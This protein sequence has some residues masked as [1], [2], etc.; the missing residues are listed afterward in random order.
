MKKRNRPAASD[1]RA[2]RAKISAETTSSSNVSTYCLCKYIQICLR[3]KKDCYIDMH[4][5]LYRPHSLLCRSWHQRALRVRSTMMMT[6]TLPW[7]W[8]WTLTC[9]CWLRICVYRVVVTV[10][11]VKDVWSHVLS[12][13]NAIILTALKS[14]CVLWEYCSHKQIKCNLKSETCSR[15]LDLRLCLQSISTDTF[16]HGFTQ[17]IC[18]WLPGA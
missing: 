9:L 7:Y 12:V 6:V 17:F 2:K 1:R 11:T 3:N 4:C 16:Y 13:D 8:L 15:V 10:L 14:R 18:V 5:L